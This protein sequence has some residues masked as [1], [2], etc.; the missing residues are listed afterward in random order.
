M[1]WMHSSFSKMLKLRCK[2][3]QPDVFFG[4][5]V[6]TM[7][8]L[9]VAVVRLWAS[10]PVNKLARGVDVAFCLPSRTRWIG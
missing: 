4:W 6:V 2:I 3:L 7:G 10:R 1:T 5:Y 9:L 8:T